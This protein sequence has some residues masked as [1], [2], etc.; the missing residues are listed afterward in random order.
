[1]VVT[2]RR[3]F[4]SRY[5]DRV[6]RP[7]AL[8]ALLVACEAN[9]GK[10]KMDWA[11]PG[12]VE[13]WQ[14]ALSTVCR[15]LK[16]GLQLPFRDIESVRSAQIYDC[17]LAGQWKPE[18]REGNAIGHLYFNGDAQ[19]TRITLHARTSKT[20]AFDLARELI[21]A[22]TATPRPV[23]I[24]AGPFE[25]SSFELTVERVQRS[26]SAILVLKIRVKPSSQ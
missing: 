24:Q 20:A 3:H 1:V 15:D 4:K 13:R 12:G 17:V 25:L 10:F 26:D 23:P 21:G 11:L 14:T 2:L 19:L 22:Y 9:P 6:S 7:I 18:A 5:R 16:L 8:L